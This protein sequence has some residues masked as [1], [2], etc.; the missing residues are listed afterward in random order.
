MAAEEVKDEWGIWAMRGVV[1]GAAG[2][3]ARQRVL[4]WRLANFEEWRRGLEELHHFDPEYVYDIGHEYDLDWTSDPDYGYGIH[5]CPIDKAGVMGWTEPWSRYLSLSMAD[6]CEDA[7]GNRV[8]EF[9][10]IYIPKWLGTDLGLLPERGLLSS[11]VLPDL[12]LLPELVVLPPMLELPPGEA[13]SPQDQM[14]RPLDGDPVPE[15]VVEMA[16]PDT[17]EWDLNGKK[18]LY[19]ALGIAEYMV[20]SFGDVNLPGV[21][22]KLLLYR[23]LDGEYRL[24]SPDQTLS[25]P[26]VPAFRS[27]VFGTR[28]RMQPG[29][30]KPQ[31]QWYDAA[32]GCWR[33]RESDKLLQFRQALARSR[34]AIRAAGF[35]EG[36]AESY[37]ES[38]AERH[39]GGKAEGLAKGYAKAAIV[40]MHDL[41]HSELAPGVRER[42]AAVWRQDGPPAD[43][44][45]RIVAVKQAP[46]EWPSLLG[47][48]DDNDDDMLGLD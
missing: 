44:V 30:G 19:A 36:F 14:I 46:K 4:A 26:G 23:L 10:E 12:M 42:I 28:L 32:K 5:V 8:V 37:A 13:R 39:V 35:V 20:C 34:Q 16:A 6:T 27:E 31:F 48:L 24:V 15:L 3:A 33:D 21:D 18:R 47:F 40:V 43:A 45:S 7:L 25:E 22:G 17:W 29:E 1:D 38:Y 11:W 41:L 2:Y 9:A